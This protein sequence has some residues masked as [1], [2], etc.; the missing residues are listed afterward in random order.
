MSALIASTT[1][2]AANPLISNKKTYKQTLP[3][4]EVKAEHLVPAME[5]AIKAHD[6]EISKIVDNPA[7]PTFANTIEAY[8]AS[9]QMLER[10]YAV[11][12][13]LRSNMADDNF[14][15]AATVITPM[16]SKHFNNISLNEE[17]FKRVKVIYDQRGKLNLT[18]EQNKLLEEI[19]LDFLDNGATLEGKDREEYRR[20]SD[21]LST[22]TLTFGQN[23]L[24]ATSAYQKHITDVELLK[25]L[26]QDVLDAAHE[27]AA[28]KGLEG[29]IF[30]LSAP[31][32]RNLLK[33]AD[34]RE[35]RHEIYVAY[36]QRAVGGEYDNLPIVKEIVNS[37][38]ALANLL[39]Y[40]DYASYKLKRKMAKNNET[41]YKLVN[42]LK[43]A[44]YPVAK[45]EAAAVQG[46]ALG[47]EHQNFQ[48]EPWDW[49]YYSNKLKDMQ[50]DL[51]DEMLRPYFELENVRK[52]VFGLAHTLYGL[53]F[54]ENKKIQV[55]H[56]DVTAYE[57]F[58]RDGEYIGLL[59]TDFFPRPEKKAGAWMNDV[60]PQSCRNGKMER[61][62]ITLNTNFTPPTADKPSLLTYDE[63]CT[64][65]HEFGHCL[66]G[67]LS[68]VTYGALAGTNVA[69]DFVE[70][71]SQIME[72]WASEKEFL[73]QFAVHYQTGEKIPMELIQ[74]VK[75]ANNFN[76]A[77]ACVRQLGFDYLDMAYHTITE[78]FEGDVR[79]FEHQAMAPVALL[80]DYNDL[81][82]STA[83]THLFNGGYAAGYYGYKWAE[84][85][86]ADAFCHYTENA[87]FD[88]ERAESFRSNILSKGGTEDAQ[89]L[90]RRFRGQDAGI[91]SLLKVNGIK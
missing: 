45:Q 52:G 37:R 17:L 83:F 63:L 34:N 39:G 58:D 24:K 76:V 2:Q 91:E 47:L 82:M 69:Q 56:K 28:A 41:V 15:K 10:V 9:G 49:S 79:D 26:P 25:G 11:Y 42:D 84:V 72:F 16:V 18:T 62:F 19:Y 61:P 55:W 53:N 7:A 57:V 65:L 20:L 27:K 71:P 35:L 32:Y 64:F 38:L 31:S 68:N 50:Y 3:F 78:P 36:M 80:P 67:L 40:P 12:A 33:Y 73:D 48:I 86:A 8:E 4:A 81:C 74:K 29:W 5:A 90:Y 89:E 1:I 44:Y 46:F 51:N 85:L 77:Y 22:L 75:D 60:K 70:L 66:H 43:E 21:R 6:A 14:M 30:D 23:C 54:K 13:I 88:L 59:Y 87:V